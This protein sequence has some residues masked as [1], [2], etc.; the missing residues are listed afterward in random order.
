MTN[1][2]QKINSVAEKILKKLPKGTRLFFS[3]QHPIYKVEFFQA[4][5]V[6]SGKV[7]VFDFDIDGNLR[8]VSEGSAKKLQSS[9]LKAFSEERLSRKRKAL[10]KKANSNV[11]NEILRL[12]ELK[13]NDSV[14]ELGAGEG[15]LTKKIAKIVKITATDFVAK[16]VKTLGKISNVVSVKCSH[17]N[18]LEKIPKNS[19]NKVMIAFATETVNEPLKVFKNIRAVLKKKGVL[20][21]A[22]NT[23][24]Y[25]HLQKLIE[26]SGFKIEKTKILDYNIGILEPRWATIIKARKV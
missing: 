24:L 7:E 23:P 21:V 11:Y 8:S 1:E 13:K 6:K 19:K 25:K 22:E 4:V 10:L 2:L 9:A 26:D 5:F 3:P 20:V 12:A 17:E 18:L 16:N 14:L 15:L